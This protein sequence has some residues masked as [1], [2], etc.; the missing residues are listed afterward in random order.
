M[1]FRREAFDMEGWF[2]DGIA[3]LV[4]D[5]SVVKKPSSVSAASEKKGVVL[6]Y[7]PDAR[8]NHH[9]TS[10]RTTTCYFLSRCFS[11]GLSNHL[12]LNLLDQEVD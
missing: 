3:G 1:S 12:W 10:Q 9:V 7:D 11:E 2:R 4:N 6:L 8:V 5:R